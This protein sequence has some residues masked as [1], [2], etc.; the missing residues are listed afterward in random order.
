MQPN[1]RG[2]YSYQVP[3][4]SNDD[5]LALK[6]PIQHSIYFAGEAYQNQDSGYAH[7]AYDSGLNVA[8]SITNC[9]ND[10]SKCMSDTPT[11]SEICSSSSA[12]TN[13]Y[14]VSILL[15]SLAAI[16]FALL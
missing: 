3:G 4:I 14:T 6:H 5:Y 15:G 8:K 16:L 2:S 9:M 1:F 11:F 7:G 12:A 13:V 10:A